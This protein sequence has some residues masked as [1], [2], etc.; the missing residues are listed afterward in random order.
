MIIS[1]IDGRLT[2]DAEH[3]TF[4]KGE[5]VSFR[6]ASQNRP[7]GDDKSATFVACTAWGQMCVNMLQ[8]LTKGKYI[9]VA[10]EL[11]RREWERDG[12]SGVELE[13][14][15]TSINP[16]VGNKSDDDTDAK[17]EGRA[18]GSYENKKE[19]SAE[20]TFGRAPKV[21]EAAPQETV[22]AIKPL[23]QEAKKEQV[24]TDVFKVDL[25]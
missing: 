5:C 16:F 21:K 6:V 14:R 18:I 3:R 22:A 4:E 25:A 11:E 9:V 23:V 8:Y 1:T 10:G 17:P 20:K 2:R 24:V 19:A 12:E 7:K 13:L 15:V